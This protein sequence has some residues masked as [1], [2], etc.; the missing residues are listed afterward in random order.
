[1]LSSLFVS[2]PSSHKTP[3]SAK[4]IGDLLSAKDCPNPN[5]IDPWWIC[6]Q[7]AHWW[8]VW[9]YSAPNSNGWLLS[10]LSHDGLGGSPCISH[11]QTGRCLICTQGRERPVACTGRPA[12]DAIFV[13]GPKH[14]WRCKLRGRRSAPVTAVS[15][16]GMVWTWCW[17]VVST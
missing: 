12:P 16:F 11:F 9:R 2:V 3:E 7:T 8:F 10:Y 6:A 17:I 13:L 5:R 14:L 1:M 4:A 15:W